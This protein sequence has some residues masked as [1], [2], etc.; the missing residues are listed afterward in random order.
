MPYL[1]GSFA[2]N[3]FRLV[4]SRMTRALAWQPMSRNLDLKG[5]LLILGEYSSAVEE[6]KAG[7]TVG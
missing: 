1:K 6:R 5:A 4:W 3:T 7:V 2:A